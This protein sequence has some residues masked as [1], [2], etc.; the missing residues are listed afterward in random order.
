[1][2]KGSR[3]E[4]AIEYATIGGPESLE[5]IHAKLDDPNEQSYQE[6]NIRD[7]RQFGINPIPFTR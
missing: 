6:V 4:D 1:M 2:L 3:L 7:A 5:K